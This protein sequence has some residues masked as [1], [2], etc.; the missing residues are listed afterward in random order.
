[1]IDSPQGQSEN[2]PQRRLFAVVPAAGR[3]RRMGR[4]K[5]LLPLGGKTVLARLLETLRPRVEAVLAVVRAD[6]A[7]LADEARARGAVVVQPAVD[8]PDMRQSVEHGLR[9]IA[10]RFRP[11][12][13]DGWLLI[14]A[15]HPVLD[16]TVIDA[17]AARWRTDP[18][19]I[20]VPT[21]AGRRG[22][23]TL[24]SWRL[25]GEVFRLPPDAGLNHLVRSRPNDVAEVGV[26]SPGALLDLDTP[27]DYEALAR[28]FER[29]TEES[30]EQRE[31]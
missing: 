14:P 13:A 12:D 9:A 19:E 3:S 15:D 26:E 17:V 11:A 27:A 1:M 10:E 6:D 7:R 25:A 16:A 20:V 5:L 8:P 18:Q 23:P 28:S 21:H 2:V 24:F 22:H 30:V 29:S 4:P 31:Q